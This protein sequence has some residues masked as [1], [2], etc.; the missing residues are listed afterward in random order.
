MTNGVAGLGG[1]QDFL[2]RGFAAFA[3]MDGAGD[4]LAF[5]EEREEE[6]VRSYFAGASRDRRRRPR[7]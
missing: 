4:F 5:V 1:F 3:A 7:A 6:L 2:E